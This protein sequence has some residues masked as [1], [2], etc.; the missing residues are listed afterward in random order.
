MNPVDEL[1]AS[2]EHGTLKACDALAADVGGRCLSC[3]A[4]RWRRR[5]PSWSAVDLA[6]PYTSRYPR[7]GSTQRHRRPPTAVESPQRFA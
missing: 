4:A 3:S 5:S 1:A 6:R 7:L 2:I